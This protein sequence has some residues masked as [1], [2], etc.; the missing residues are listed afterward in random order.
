MK[1]WVTHQILCEFA[2]APSTT[3]GINTR[4]QSTDA[5]CSYSQLAFA[6]PASHLPHCLSICCCCWAW[7]RHPT[8]LHCLHLNYRVAAEHCHPGGCCVHLNMPLTKKQRCGT[9]IL[10]FAHMASALSLNTDHHGKT[11]K[12]QPHCTPTSQSPI[13]RA[14]SSPTCKL[15]IL[16]R[17]TQI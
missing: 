7:D 8:L 5:G 2:G 13:V 10:R 4:V 6:L 16:H 1:R 14:T 15:A 12:Q 17:S 11:L 9:C 3:G